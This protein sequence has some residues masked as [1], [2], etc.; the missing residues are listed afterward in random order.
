MGLLF[1]VYAGFFAEFRSGSSHTIFSLGCVGAGLLVGLVSFL[2]GRITVLRVIRG[3]AGRLDELC[4]AEGDLTR[5]I[6]IVSSDCIGALASNF[7]RFLAKLRDLVS[8]LVEI[9][10]G[11]QRVGFEL[12]A[13][14]T[15]TSAASEQI[16]R[17]MDMIHRRTGV[18][19]S[20]VD[21]VNEARGRIDAS[22]ASVA[23]SINLQSDSLTRLSALVERT[24]EELRTISS[25]TSGEAL[26]IAASIEISNRN[27]ED[28]MRVAGKVREI[29]KSVRGI[30]ELAA[31]IGDIA[32]R[33]GILGINASI[34]ASHAGQAGRGFAVVAAE[35]RQARRVRRP[36]LL[37][38]QRAPQGRR[39][40]RRRRRG[41]RGVHGAGPHLPLGG[42]QRQRRGHQGGSR[43]LRA[44]DPGGG[45]HAPRPQ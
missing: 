29:D 44:L 11:A 34:E 9:A 28:F 36:R 12:A 17:H 2:I 33:I 18:L 24:V 10:D 43:P 1:P 39:R 42:Y 38:H 32:E 15:E 25:L 20:E 19:I 31:S 8:R 7:D 30:G 27:L 3:V 5:D 13:N 26:S 45:I 16:S 14:S 40:P 4:E 35:I 6:G 41:S 22:A 37:P 23:E 21:H